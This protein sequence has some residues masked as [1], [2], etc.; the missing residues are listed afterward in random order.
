MGLSPLGLPPWILLAALVGVA[1]GAL[2][3]LLFSP[4]LERLPL[5]VLV[6]VVSA[7]LVGWVGVQLGPTPWS[8]GEAHL[9]AICG[10]AWSALAIAR[11]TGL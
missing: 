2:F 8:I 1:S 5:Y 4:R 9:L 3:H 6:G 11:L 10:A 7:L